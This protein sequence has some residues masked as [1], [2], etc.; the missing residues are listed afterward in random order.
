MIKKHFPNFSKSKRA[1]AAMEFLMTYGWALMVVLIVIGA[2]AFF[3]LLNPDKFLPDKVE[4]GTGFIVRS[5]AV[6]ENGIQ[7]LVFNGIGNPARGFQIEVEACENYV[8]GGAYDTGNSISDITT[9]GEGETEMFTIECTGPIEGTKFKSDLTMY[10]ST[11][12]LS[13]TITHEQSGL[14]NVEVGGELDLVGGEL[15]LGC[16]ASNCGS[17]GQGDCS[18]GCSWDGAS[19]NSCNPYSCSSCTQT[20]CEAASGCAWTGSQCIILNS[21]SCESASDQGTCEQASGCGFS[22]TFGC[23]SCGT[24]NCGSCDSETCGS[25]SECANHWS[26]ACMDVEDMMWCWDINDENGC[27]GKEGCSWSGG[28][29]CD[30]CTEGVGYGCNTEEDC[31]ESGSYWLTNYPYSDDGTYCTDKW[32]YCYYG[33]DGDQSNCEADSLCVWYSNSCRPCSDECYDCTSSS[34]CNVNPLC[35]WGTTCTP[36]T[37]TCPDQCG[38][39]TDQS[40]CESAGCI[41]ASSTS[42][43][44]LDMTGTSCWDLWN[45]PE[46]VCEGS[47][48]Y[49]KDDYCGFCNSYDFW[50]CPD[51]TTCEAAGGAWMTDYPHSSSG[52]QCVYESDLCYYSYQGD[53]AGCDGDPDCGWYSSGYCYYCGNGNC[54]NCWQQGMCETVEGCM[55][56]GSSCTSCSSSACG[57]CYD[58]TTCESVS[59]IWDSGSSSCLSCDSQHCTNCPDQTNCESSDGCSWDGASCNTCNEY[60]CSGCT[61]TDCGST[62][63]CSWSGS[64]CEVCNQYTC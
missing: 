6:G 34:Y 57:A 17:C 22:S 16:G 25:S 62:T 10:Y 30:Y 11:K 33:Y 50:Y 53:E 9:I 14:L 20:D 23:T 8:E 5:V 49:M 26:G 29:W 43:C 4:M 44:W 59:C 61:Q 12:V 19:C 3:G 58:Q 7:I 37:E 64:V 28:G 46:E 15:D 42:E 54:G 51:Q 55:W 47:G 21:F 60:S 35:T 41:W 31:E 24:G 52:E 36:I 63:G 32:G 38:G 40:T 48:C 27:N 13:E 45:V 18:S 1:Q 56:D 39:C 2:L